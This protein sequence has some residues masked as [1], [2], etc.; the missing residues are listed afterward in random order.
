MRCEEVR[1]ALP[2]STHDLAVR[3]HLSRCPGCKAELAQFETLM[4]GLRTLQTHTAEA[5]PAL[6]TS[7]YAIPSR[8]NRLQG[9]RDHVVRHRKAYAGGLVAV[10]AGAAA[11]TLVRNR[12]LRVA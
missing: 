6:L 5:P 12:R 10:A 7:L 3:R 8:S 1:E 11:A 2:A 4:D 9:A